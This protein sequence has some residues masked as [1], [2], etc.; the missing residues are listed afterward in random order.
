[1]TDQRIIS[2][3]FHVTRPNPHKGSF[4]KGI[5]SPVPS[6]PEQSCEPKTKASYQQQEL[7]VVKATVIL[8]SFL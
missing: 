1:M 4:P 3:K 5:S 7:A 8:S 2:K 6:L